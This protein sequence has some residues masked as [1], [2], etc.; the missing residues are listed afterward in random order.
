MSAAAA[1]AVTFPVIADVLLTVVSAMVTFRAVFAV[2][3]PS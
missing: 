3:M 2:M 1:M